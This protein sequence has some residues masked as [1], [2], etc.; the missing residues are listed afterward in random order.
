MVIKEKL[1]NPNYK[2][3]AIANLISWLDNGHKAA[4]ATVIST[5]GSSPCPPGSHLAIRDD[6][7]IVG[8]VSAGCVE[9]AVI[10]QSMKAIEGAPPQ[11]CEYGVSG[12]LAW[13]VGLAC[14]GEIKIFVRS[15][16]D[17]AELL[18]ETQK[19]VREGL[20][21]CLVTR[22]SDASSTLF[23]E[24]IKNDKKKYFEG[25][26][27]LAQKAA[28][29]NKSFISVIEKESFFFEAI[30]PPRCL[31]IIGAVHIAQ[32]L[33]PMAMIIGF[34]VVVID[35]RKSFATSER[36]PGVDI[37]TDWPDQVITD[38]SVN[39][40]TAIVVLT[41]DPKIDD[42]VL[43]SSL[44]SPSFYVGALGSSRTN[45]KRLNRL[46]DLGLDKKALNR[47]HGPVGLDI[48]SKLPAEIAI[49]ILA[50]II[51]EIRR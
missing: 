51:Q 2:T 21:S 37:R 46:K 42:Q 6:G 48:G 18:R 40:R 33:A 26:D 5:W 41:H 36:F 30:T 32:A 29:E 35:P 34:K 43:R 49:A 1:R 10:H 14:G 13:E 4:L 47:L 28:N 31:I 20:S 9:S 8:S 38:L 25:L 15:I 3:D 23:G 44:E 19:R 24:G 11:V 17:G 16:K 27:E 7:I 50:E 39:N 45:E 22:I 12:E